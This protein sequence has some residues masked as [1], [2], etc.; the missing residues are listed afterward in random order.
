LYKRS[1]INIIKPIMRNLG[2]LSGEVLFI[3]KKEKN[4][5]KRTERTDQFVRDDCFAL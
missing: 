2:A 1:T 5:L 4:W 3:I